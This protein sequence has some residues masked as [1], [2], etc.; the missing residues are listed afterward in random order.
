M[1]VAHAR[2]IYVAIIGSDT[3][4]AARP[5]DPL[6]LTRACL[7][8]G[9]DLVVPVSWGEEV[10][11]HDLA[12]QLSRNASPE[13]AVAAACPLAVEALRSTPI[14]TGVL[15]TVSPPV[16]T[17]RYMRAML[18]PRR[19]H[20]TYVGACPGASNPE[21]DV[22]CAPQVLFA[23]LVDS[24]IDVAHQPRHLDAQ[25]PMERSRYA[26]QPGGMPEARW[27]G[28]RTHAR[29]T[30]AAPITV[31]VVAQLYREERLLFDV[32][33]ACR[34][35]CAQDRTAIARLEPPRA[36]TPVIADSP[37]QVTTPF[38][39]EADRETV[40]QAPQRTAPSERPDRSGENGVSGNASQL[41]D[42]ANRLTQS[43][44]PW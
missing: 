14:R 43:R 37:V 24:G 6:Q 21:I 20:V 35:I 1:S 5:A 10:I 17:A 27:L 31:D 34:C 38:M 9:F 40:D 39:A 13:S 25:L 29:V 32:T 22:H 33:R 44:E 11:A 15:G 28:A 41:L 4:L 30:E 36:S 26:S 2:P 16:A 3:L 18:E 19:V 12:E 23:K 7:V 42:L 8:A